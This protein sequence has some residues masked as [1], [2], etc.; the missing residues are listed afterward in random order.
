[1]L[2]ATVDTSVLNA[3][4]LELQDALVASGGNGDLSQVVADEARLLAW[5]IARQVGPR[6]VSSGTKKITRDVKRAYAAENPKFLEG[7]KRD[8]E[9]FDWVV[10]TSEALVGF[11]KSDVRT[12]DSSSTLTEQMAADLKQHQGGNIRLGKRGK[13]QVIRRNKVL[14]SKPSLTGL[15]KLRSQRIGRLKA[16]FAYTAAQLGQQ[17]IPR[18]VSVHFD[19]LRSEGVAIYQGDKLRDPQSPQIVFGSGA[20]AVGKHAT[21]VAGAVITRA[22]KMAA[23]IQDI[24]HGY[25]Q[26]WMAGRKIRK[27][28]KRK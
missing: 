14:I 2:T 17:R 21:T 3:R 18:W 23:K 10:A 15:I 24:I 1:M 19:S 25:S 11:A 16:S 26:D 13:Q 27:G 6:S 4:L 12:G 9:K 20:Y 5:E 7:K 22:E 8:G 28:F